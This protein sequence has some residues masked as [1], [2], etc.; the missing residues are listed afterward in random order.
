V[1]DQRPS[2]KTDKTIDVRATLELFGYEPTAATATLR[3]R[4][5]SWRVGGAVRTMAIALVVAP[6]VT[7]IPPHA[8]WL[9]GVL[10][11]GGLLAR[12]R[13]NEHFTVEGV[14]GACP[15][16]GAP[17]TASRGRLRSPHPVTCDACHFEPNLRVPEEA[18]NGAGTP[19]D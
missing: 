19:L 10:A 4:T 17:V 13:L 3:P 15:K 2:L 18:V 1:N 6:V 16:C 12:R 8:P 11:G 5:R 9:I 14:D 7:V